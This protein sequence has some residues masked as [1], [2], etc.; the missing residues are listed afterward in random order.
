MSKKLTNL[1]AFVLVLGLVGYAGASSS[2]VPPNGGEISENWVAMG[3]VPGATAVSFDVYLG[4]NYA[5]VEAGTGGTARG[6]VDTP[7][8][9][10]GFF[11]TPYPNVL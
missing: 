11:G 5:H 8:F 4:D 7:T 6:R 10:A 1:V 3:W 9:I 2:P